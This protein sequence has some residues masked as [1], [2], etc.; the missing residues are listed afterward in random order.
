M[1]DL[2]HLVHSL[3]VH[4]RLVDWPGNLKYKPL[5]FQQFPLNRCMISVYDAQQISTSDYK[6]ILYISTY[7]P[8][9]SSMD[10]VKIM[11]H[12]LKKLYLGHSGILCLKYIFMTEGKII[13]HSHWDSKWMAPC[14]SEHQN[15]DKKTS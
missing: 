8:K 15:I 4:V 6:T 10:K 1:R 2:R 13:H 5:L 11:E 12:N 9:N 7:G 14:E 3:S